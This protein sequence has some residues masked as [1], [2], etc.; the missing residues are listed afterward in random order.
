MPLGSAVV[1]ATLRP[2]AGPRHDR[3]HDDVGGNRHA[4]A[5]HVRPEHAQDAAA[6]LPATSAATPGCGSQAD[7]MLKA[8]V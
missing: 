7:A 3:D 8:S 4:L 1:A 2:S 6:D 5:S